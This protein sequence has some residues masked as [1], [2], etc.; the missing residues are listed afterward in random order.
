MTL[1]EIY[2]RVWFF[3]CIYLWFAGFVSQCVE[4]DGVCAIGGF[5]VYRPQA[6]PR[7]TW[8]EFDPRPDIKIFSGYFYSWMQ[9]LMQLDAIGKKK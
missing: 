7:V 4:G 6:I 8:F 5:E 9:Q 3:L 1:I 2:M